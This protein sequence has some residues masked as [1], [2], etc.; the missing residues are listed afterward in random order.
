MK[1]KKRKRRNN[2]KNV[3]NKIEIYYNNIN[4][5]ITKQD[6]LH[7]ILQMNQ[8]DIVAICETKLHKNS[9]YDISGYKVIK[10]N[11]KAGK[12]GILVAVKEGTYQTAEKI[13]ESERRNLATIE[14]TYPEDTM[15][16]IVVHGPQEDAPH[17]EKDEF[18]VDLK[19][20]VECCASSNSRML[21][22]GDFNARLEISGNKVEGVSSNGKQ[23][24]EVVEVYDLVIL[25]MQ[26]DTEGKWTRIQKKGNAECKS[27]IDYLITDQDTRKITSKTHVDEEKLYTPYRTKKDSRG[28]TLVFSDHCAMTTCVE[29]CKGTRKTKLKPQKMKMW[30][31]DAPG[32]KK[33][34]KIGTDNVDLGKMANY[35]NPY[36]VWSNEVD[37]VMHQCFARKT[38]TIG[39][40][41]PSKSR[42]KAKMIRAILKG[43]A[44]K[45]K[46]QREIVKL[47]H[48]KLIHL[49]ANRNARL[50]AEKLNETV[51]NLTSDDILSPNAFW[52]LRKSISKNSGL[53]LQAVLKREGG[54]TNDPY[55]I[56]EE[57]RKEF[58]YRL[59]DREAE[60][61]WEGYVHATNAVVELILNEHSDSGPDFTEEEL[62]AAIHKMK[63]GI[64][65]DYH[66]MHSEVLHNLGTG[67]FK[68]LLEVM[69]IIKNTRNIPIKWSNVLITMIYKNKG[70]HMDLEKYRG[71]FLTVMVAKVFERLLQNRMKPQL[72][73]ISLF[74]AGS[75]SGRGPSDNL[76]LLR[77]CIDHSKYMNKCLYITSYD[78]R[79]AFDSLWMQDCI[80]VLKKLGVQNY[81]LQLIYELNKKAIVQVKTPYG[82]TEPL[83]ITNAVKQGGVLGSSLC[84]AS[85]GE[86][87]HVN[88]GITI[89]D[90]QIA[91][92][93]YV[94]DIFDVNDNVDDTTVAHRNAEIFAKRKKQTH[95]PEKCN[96][97]LVNKRNKKGVKVP[98]LKIDSEIIEETHSMVC[99]GDVFNSKGNNDDLIADRMKRGTAVMISTH[100]F[101]REMSLGVHTI[102]VYLL[103]HSAIFLASILFNAQA[104]SNL[105]EK[106]MLLLSTMQ[107]KFLKK[108]MMV[109]QA[110]SNSFVCLE[111]GV[112]P[113]EYE[114]HK[115]QLSF[116]HHIIHLEEDDPVKRMW[117][118]QKQLPEHNNWWNGVEKLLVK[119]NIQLTEEDM[120]KMSKET[121]K[122]KIKKIVAYVAFE[123]LKAD[124]QSKRKTNHLIYQKFE[125]QSYVTSL[126]PKQ[127]RMIFKCRSR[128]LNIKDHM[129][130][131]FKDNQH[132]R[133][134]GVSNETLQHIVNCGFESKIDDVEAVLE[135]GSNLDLMGE[136]AERV[137]EFL[138]RVEV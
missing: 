83:E 13:F 36:D 99:L 87:C 42:P 68:S 130:Y 85:T 120:K 31:I 64:A 111:L 132:C 71:I 102:S 28:E 4:G 100:G 88:K 59:R 105:T 128:T 51:A 107:M 58:E 65:P 37:K 22:A 9:Q 92:L 27:V 60:D 67:L 79:Q 30:V 118:N 12:E 114:I 5:L 14:I 122:Q 95:A 124:C 73:K 63:T 86:Y 84:S 131:K 11:L 90:L 91:T 106:N 78:F 135:L 16:V 2:N 32:L 38:V 34:Q 72:D 21:I 119:Y 29:I 3:Q 53:N 1:H 96:V 121:Y 26:Q 136:I 44:E 52:K 70:S 18:F 57:V 47:Y 15:R 20:E 97:M 17:D 138:E 43:V 133:W 115:R 55:E 134:C 46:I 62:A 94:D 48:E 74:Q 41:K 82:L 69:N 101:M 127:S 6:S 45:G 24:M 89:G 54:T 19:A 40:S 33:F 125:A 123:D 77:G 104:W 61:G 23:L 113:V 75:R 98:E 129:E 39:R 7:H 35:N 56:K 10:S 66:S 126:Y 112:L 25:N 81:I 109:K 8:P 110:V 76:F 117:K 103:L 108:T 49:E 116:L 93:A 50:R 137:A 80:L